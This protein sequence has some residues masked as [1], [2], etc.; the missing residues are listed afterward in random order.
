V[1]PTLLGVEAGSNFNIWYQSLT[2]AERHP[3][4]LTAALTGDKD[5]SIEMDLPPFLTKAGWVN[6]LHRFLCKISENEQCTLNP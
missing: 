1:D 4:L 6:Q 2:E 5:D 3:V